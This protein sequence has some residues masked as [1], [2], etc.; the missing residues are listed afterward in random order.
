M[1]PWFKL[2]IIK[3]DNYSNIL[4]AKMDVTPEELCKDMPEAFKELYE[5]TKSLNN[6]D[7]IDYD[8]IQNYLYD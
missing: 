4:Q 8:K 1:L 5:Y 7:E 3:G 2:P 6:N